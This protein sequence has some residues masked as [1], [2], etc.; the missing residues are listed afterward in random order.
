M[1]ITYKRKYKTIHYGAYITRILL[2]CQIDIPDTSTLSVKEIGPKTLKLMDIDPNPS[3]LEHMSFQAWQEHIASQPETPIAESSSRRRHFLQEEEE[4]ED[5]QIVS[6][7]LPPKQALAVLS[8][9][10]S[11]IHKD[12]KRF[13][14]KTNKKFDSLRNLTKFG[15]K[16]HASDLNL[17]KLTIRLHSNGLPVLTMKKPQT[18]ALDMMDLKEVM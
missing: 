1:D 4:K 5:I 12:L 11:K 18:Q 17:L 9:N 2:E 15:I 16:F 7:D 8:R 10:Q 13:E 3:T 6:P 14:H